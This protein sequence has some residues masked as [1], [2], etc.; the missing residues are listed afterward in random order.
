MSTLPETTTALRDLESLLLSA[1]QGG[2]DPAVVEERVQYV[3]KLI[4]REEVRWI[5]TKKAKRLLG[6]ELEDSVR[7]WAELGLLRSR[8]LPDGRLQVRLDDVLYRRAEREALMAIGGEELSPEELRI[9]K[10]GRPGKNPW[11]REQAEQA[12]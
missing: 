7:V 4:A 2:L 12:R 11:E 6:I 9:L 5:G 8:T 3:L 1:P 10:E